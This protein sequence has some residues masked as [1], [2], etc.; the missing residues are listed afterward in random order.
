MLTRHNAPIGKTDFHAGNPNAAHAV[1]DN[2]RI[3]ISKTLRMFSPAL[4]DIQHLRIAV[5]VYYALQ[6]VMGKWSTSAGDPKRSL[7]QCFKRY[8][9]VS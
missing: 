2:K 6:T 8:C 7:P 3:A 4:S 9:S 1:N 5:A